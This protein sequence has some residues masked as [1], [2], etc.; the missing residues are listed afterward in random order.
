MTD[1]QAGT[2][3]RPKQEQPPT[4]PGGPAPEVEEAV[5]ESGASSGGGAAS[6]SARPAG[7]H[8]VTDEQPLPPLPVPDADR[9]GELA[10]RLVDTDGDGTADVAVVNTPDVP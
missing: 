4:V 9:D 5:D 7:L 8:G 6:P 3:Q 1:E 10:V 2:D